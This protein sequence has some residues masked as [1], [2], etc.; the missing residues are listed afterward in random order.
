MVAALSKMFKARN[1]LV[2]ALV[3]STF[4]IFTAEGRQIASP[5]STQNSRRQLNGGNWCLW[6]V[7]HWRTSCFPITELLVEDVQ[8][9]THTHTDEEYGTWYIMWEATHQVTICRFSWFRIFRCAEH[10]P[11]TRDNRAVEGSIW[12]ILWQ[13]NHFCTFYVIREWHGLPMDFHWFF[14]NQ[15]VE[16]NSLKI[17]QFFLCKSVKKW[18]FYS[19]TKF[20]PQW[21]SFDATAATSTVPMSL[22]WTF[23]KFGIPAATKWGTVGS[24]V[25]LWG[26]NLQRM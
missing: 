1:V 4:I 18:A 26:S 14:S 22:I 15:H 16:E 13:I 2:S 24:S 17:L 5:N 12:K 23:S 9:E 11:Q 7:E 21:S 19:S 20:E 10:S 8:E 25:K 3:A 6:D